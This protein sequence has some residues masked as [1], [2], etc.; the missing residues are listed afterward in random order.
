MERLTAVEQFVRVHAFA[1]FVVMALALIIFHAVMY[2]RERRSIRLGLGLKSRLSPE[3]QAAHD[4]VNYTCPNCGRKSVRYGF[5]QGSSV[6]E[7]MGTMRRTCTRC[8]W[9]GNG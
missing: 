9:T 5:G 8:G 6:A 3:E 1:V 7:V 2:V 4:A